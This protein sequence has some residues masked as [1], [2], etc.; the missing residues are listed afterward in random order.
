MP[1]YGDDGKGGSGGDV[2]YGSSANTPNVTSGNFSGSSNQTTTHT[3]SNQ[4]DEGFVKHI[5]KN[6]NNESSISSGNNYTEDNYL[7]AVKWQQ[8]RDVL[9]GAGF[10]KTI[11]ALEPRRAENIEQDRIKN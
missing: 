9:E 7:A 10:I 5:P 4:V 2:G 3:S 6:T 8:V 1:G 11:E